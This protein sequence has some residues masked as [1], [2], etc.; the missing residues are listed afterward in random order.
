MDHKP[1]FI[2]RYKNVSEQKTYEQYIVPH[3]RDKSRPVP[4]LD[5]LRYNASLMFGNS[6]YSLG[7]PIK[8]PQNYIPIAGYHIDTETKPLPKVNMLMTL[9]TR[10]FFSHL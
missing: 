6:H 2:S 9:L 7:R 8:L 1:Y 10:F 4:S 3:I 5:V